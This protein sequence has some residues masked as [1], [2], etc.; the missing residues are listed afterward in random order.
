MNDGLNLSAKV[1]VRLTKLDNNGN[2]VGIDEHECS[3]TR[4]EAEKLWQLQKQE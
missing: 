3:L 4:E 2:V 1:K